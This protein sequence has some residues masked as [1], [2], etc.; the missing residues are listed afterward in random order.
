MI[1]SSNLRVIGESLKIQDYLTDQLPIV[2]SP[3][4]CLDGT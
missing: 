1:N 2:N 3:L 4:G